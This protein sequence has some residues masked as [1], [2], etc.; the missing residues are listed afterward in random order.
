[1]NGKRAGI[2]KEYNSYGFLM[3]EGEYLYGWKYKGKEYIKGI[4][5]FEGEY[6]NDK[7]WDGKGYD[8]NGNVIYELNNGNGK[9]KYYHEIDDLSIEGEYSNGKLKGKVKEYNRIG[10]VIFEGEYLHGVRHGNGSKFNDLGIL[11]FEGEYFN[12]KKW[13]G[14]GYDNEGK[15]IYELKDGKGIIKDNNNYY[16]YLNGEINGKV[17]YYFNKEEEI[18]EGEYSK[19]KKNGKAKEYLNDVLIFEGEYL[20]GKKNGKAKEYFDK[21]NLYFEGEYLNGKKNGKGKLYYSDGKLQF[22][23]EF[24]NG[25]NGMGKNMIKIQM[26]YSN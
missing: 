11:E 5:E 15:V 2:G 3:F 25:K 22:E 14:I 1:M 18:F 23:G 4:L 19:G 17:K 26:F 12:G 10:K 13:N 21:D 7:K 9:V 8:K 20:N 6:L 16:E 24:L